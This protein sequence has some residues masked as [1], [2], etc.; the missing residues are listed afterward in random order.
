MGGTVR[1]LRQAQIL[2]TARSGGGVRVG[3]LSRRFGVSGP[4]IRRDLADL[5]GRGLLARVHGGAVRRSADPAP[6]AAPESIV[7]AVARAAAGLVRPGVAVGLSAGPRA[8][9]LATHLRGTPGLT[10]VTPSL[11][12]ATRL[13][14]AEE[15][16]VILVGGIRTSDGGH[17]GPVA[18][19]TL[20]QVN[21]DVVF[22]DVRGMSARTGYTAEDML[23]AQTDQALL[24]RAARIVVLADHTA[25]STIGVATIAPLPAADTV[26]ADAALPP[27]ARAALR[28]AG[29]TLIIVPAP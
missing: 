24:R 21:L 23:T 3:D 15:Q 20:S 2:A 14:H 25:W 5:A 26:I 8:E 17:A 27:D 29:P 16:V 10:I 9:R 22:L 28:L 7:D 6:R 18:L 4:T 12:A 1:Q 19:H 13:A 11:P